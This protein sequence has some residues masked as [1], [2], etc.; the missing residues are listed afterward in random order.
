MQSGCREEHGGGG[1]RGNGDRESRGPGRISASAAPGA[2]NG[3]VHRRVA[4]RHPGE[5]AHNG[6]LEDD[7]AEAG[8]GGIALDA[9]QIMEEPLHE[10]A[11]H[12]VIVRRAALGIPGFR[13]RRGPLGQHHAIAGLVALVVQ[14]VDHVG[15]IPIRQRA[16]QIAIPHVARGEAFRLDV[17]HNVLQHGGAMRRVHEAHD[18]RDGVGT[19]RARGILV[20]FNVKELGDEGASDQLRL[21][22]EARLIVAAAQ[23]LGHL[24]EDERVLIKKRCARHALGRQ[25]G[26]ARLAGPDVV[27]ITQS[28]ADDAILGATGQIVH[29]P[30]HVVVVDAQQ[31]EIARELVLLPRDLQ[32]RTAPFGRIPAPFGPSCDRK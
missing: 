22:L 20:R 18:E 10:L 1:E 25:L 11:Q 4:G 2:H 26:G 19:L 6:G 5:V 31:L 7:L 3:A 14:V 32:E 9:G 15:A 12:E 23:H 24:G 8:A 13:Q 29:I 17:G 28:E 21:L 27:P 30:H 16:Q